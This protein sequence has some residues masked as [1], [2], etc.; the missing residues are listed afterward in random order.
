MMD[1]FTSM[2]LRFF[3]IP[4]LAKLWPNLSLLF[5]WSIP[6]ASYM[7]LKQQWSRILWVKPGWLVVT[8]AQKGSVL[9]R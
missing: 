2:L 4:V 1:F 5:Q 7:R 3:Q 9:G 6:A 8:F